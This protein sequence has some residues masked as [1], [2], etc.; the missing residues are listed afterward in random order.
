MPCMRLSA[1]LENL[2][3]VHDFVERALPVSLSAER[4]RIRLAAEELF[5]NV[6]R[7][8]YSEDGEGEVL[9][10]CHEREREGEHFFC[11]SVSDQ[12]PPFNPLEDADAP[13]LTLSV[14]KRPVGGLG[15][16][17]LKQVSSRQ[18]YERRDGVNTVEVGFRSPA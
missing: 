10:E 5:V 14:E 6:F 12:G 16:H 13:D 1:R 18:W 2:P 3:L 7:Y 9:I 17:L 8:A 4:D 15:I 11:L